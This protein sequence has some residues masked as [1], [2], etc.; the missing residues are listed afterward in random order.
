MKTVKLILLSIL[1]T[2]SVVTFASDIPAQFRGQWGQTAKACNPK[3]IESEGLF[4][5]SNKKIDGYEMG[6]RLK[7]VKTSTDVLFDGV[8]S[9]DVEGETSNIQ[10][11]F[12]LLDGGKVIISNGERLL[13][14]K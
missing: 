9:C 13:R 7:K 2:A 12:E 8:F 1:A 14:C 6:C 3:A 5:I 11:K 10:Y 4:K